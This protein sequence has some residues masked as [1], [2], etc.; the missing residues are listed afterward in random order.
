MFLYIT[1]DR[2]GTQTGGGSVT[3]H[4]SQA[5]HE[6]GL[7]HDG[8]HTPISIDHTQPP[9]NPFE[10]DKEI[11]QRVQDACKHDHPI[12][13]HCYAG[14]LTETVAY[15][16]SLGCRVVYTAAAH[17]VGLSMQEHEKLG[18]PFD[19]P[20][21][22]D[23][24][25]WKQYLGGYQNA[26]V[27]VC[28]SSHSADVMRMYD[29]KQR[30]EII[31][32]GCYL[33]ACKTCSG[34]G[35][36]NEGGIPGLC[37]VCKG[38]GAVPTKPLPDVFRV[39]YLG[40]FGPDKGVRY[41]LEA[42]KK[43]AY[44][45]AVL[46]LGGRDSTSPYVRQLIEQFGGGNVVLRGWV[47]NAENFYNDC[48]LY[49]QPSVT[50]GFGMEVLEAMSCGREVVCSAG[51]GAADL[52]EPDWWYSPTDVD[53]LAGLIDRWYQQHKDEAM[54]EGHY[55][56]EQAVQFT[57]DKIQARYRKLWLEVLG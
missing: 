34:Y 36:V 1:A 28:P 3:H 40:A 22:T 15:L 37:D 52:L 18:V 16:K 49:I 54:G 7:D 53:A 41:L 4:E 19:Y 44:K 51:A 10:Q 43:L 30:I 17:N 23:P 11:L 24:K 35:E 13:A 55:N 20:H 26:D 57:W 31:P 48:S 50:E 8:V 29:C 33:P 6:L 2:I 27:L 38:S 56:R 14:C 39:G 5:L 45:D 12:L 46:M 9:K 25:L 42:W 32:H 21:L 47:D